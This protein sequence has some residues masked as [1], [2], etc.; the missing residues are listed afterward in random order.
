M[1]QSTDAPIFGDFDEDILVHFLSTSNDIHTRCHKFCFKFHQEGKIDVNLLRNPSFRSSKATLFGHLY[2]RLQHF[3]KALE[4]F[5]S[6]P[7]NSADEFD[8]L[9]GQGSIYLEYGEYVKSVEC[10]EKALEI[11][12]QNEQPLDITL[13]ACVNNLAMA[14]RNMGQYKKAGVKMEEAIEKHHQAYGED[15]ETV[16]LSSLMLNLGIGYASDDPRSAIG[17]YE[18]VEGMHNR[19]MDVPDQHAI[20]LSLNMAC[21]LSELNQLERSLEYMKRALQ[22][23]HQVYGKNNQSSK[24]AQIY[25]TAGTVYKNC[26]QNMRLCLG[27]NEV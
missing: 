12:Y 23:G 24:L 16:I 2:F 19:L 14:L 15:S 22:L 6:V 1:E 17:T 21:S 9:C 26:N 20:G 27:T 4:W 25:K 8:S 5:E 13:L 10:F 7:K 3:P 11:Y 18:V